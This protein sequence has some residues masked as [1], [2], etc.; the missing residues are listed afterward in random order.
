MRSG[1]WEDVYFTKMFQNAL[2]FGRGAS[3]I[4]DFKKVWRVFLSDDS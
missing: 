2:T 3:L 1:E 4:I